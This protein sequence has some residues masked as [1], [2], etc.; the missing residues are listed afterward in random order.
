MWSDVFEFPRN[1]SLKDS[2]CVFVPRA[3]P[4]TGSLSER[5]LELFKLSGFS[6]AFLSCCRVI[7][8][9]IPQV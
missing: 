8:V 5:S 4:T 9:N 7:G 1:D 2:E 6:A 3:S